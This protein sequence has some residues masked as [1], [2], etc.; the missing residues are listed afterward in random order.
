MKINIEECPPSAGI[1]GFFLSSGEGET[2]KVYGW[3]RNFRLA[4]KAR[5]R[6]KS[7]LKLDPNATVRVISEVWK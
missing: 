5:T 1:K 2:Y 7:D 6:L 3:A 4:K